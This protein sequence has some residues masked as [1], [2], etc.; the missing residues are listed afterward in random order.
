[1]TEIDDLLNEYKS[2][3]SFK[4]GS[5]IPKF[6][7]K[8]GKILTEEKLKVYSDAV[9]DKLIE[10][11]SYKNDFKLLSVV[12]RNLVELKRVWYPATQKSIQANVNLFSE[13]LEKWIIARKE[14]AKLKGEDNKVIEFEIE[15]A[16]KA[17]KSS[18]E[19]EKEIND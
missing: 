9:L 14:L 6:V 4:E 19:L 13:Q 16:E 17:T 15:N 10:I 8:E 3:T 2:N 5:S 7:D 12:L 18:I 11:A 1:M